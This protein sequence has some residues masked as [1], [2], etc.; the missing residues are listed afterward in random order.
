MEPKIVITASVVVDGVVIAKHV[1]NITELADLV[2]QAEEDAA[3]A[4]NGWLETG[5]D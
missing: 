2:R 3:M 4:K 1:G 5:G